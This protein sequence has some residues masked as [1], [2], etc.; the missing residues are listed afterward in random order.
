MLNAKDWAITYY[1]A[2]EQSDSS[3]LYPEGARRWFNEAGQYHREDGP[4]FI[5][6]DGSVDWYINDKSYFF[7]DWCD[8]VSISDEAK[9]MLRLQYV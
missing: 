5:W 7:D 8:K 9:M 2:V 1:N 6:H 4:A 3:Y